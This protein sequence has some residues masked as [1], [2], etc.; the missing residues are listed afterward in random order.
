MFFS[1]AVS[2]RGTER[3]ACHISPVKHL[4]R[5]TE[6]QS[7]MPGGSPEVTAAQL[8]S[9]KTKIQGLLGEEVH[10]G[11]IFQNM[12]FVGMIETLKASL[13]CSGGW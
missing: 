9:Q 8:L 1:L 7:D 11:R 4:K 2:L 12:I 10:P 5:T 3:L 6:V 13:L